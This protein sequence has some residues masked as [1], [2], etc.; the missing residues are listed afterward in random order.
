MAPILLAIELLAPVAIGP[1]TRFENQRITDIQFSPAEMLDERDLA[2]AVPF[3]KGDVLKP[4]DIARAI[5][6]LFPPAASK[7]LWLKA[8]APAM[9]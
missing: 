9:A 7:T 8:N 3:K 1:V 4:E 6:G 5:D 2:R